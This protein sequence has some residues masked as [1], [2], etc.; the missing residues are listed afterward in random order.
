MSTP[1]PV[2][3]LEALYAPPGRRPLALASADHFFWQPLQQ[4]HV[5]PP[6]PPAPA[7]G[8]E[9]IP[10]PAT[11]SS[12]YTAPAPAP[13]AAAAS[14]EGAWGRLQRVD[15][16]P[17]EVSAIVEARFAAHAAAADRAPVSSRAALDRDLLDALTRV[18]QGA[19]FA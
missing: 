1:A 19:S 3:Q 9:Y 16:T 12:Y 6:P 13:S 5:V 4:K 8:L 14:A 11:V 10:A 2:P 18:Q 17:D 15:P 7:P